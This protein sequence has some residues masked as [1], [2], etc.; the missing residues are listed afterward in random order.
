MLAAFANAAVVVVF[1]AALH[2][3]NHAHTDDAPEHV[4]ALGEVFGPAAA[5]VP[6]VQLLE[7]HVA[8]RVAPE[9]RASAPVSARTWSECG[10]RDPPAAPP[11]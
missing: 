1:A 6:A 9:V 3:V 5:A 11:V 10:V 2:D 8:A 4:H 7:R